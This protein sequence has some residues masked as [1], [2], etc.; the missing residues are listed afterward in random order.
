LFGSDPEQIANGSLPQDDD[1]D[2][3]DDDI[4][5][6][7]NQ[8]MQNQSVAGDD[9]AKTETSPENDDQTDL[10]AIEKWVKPVACH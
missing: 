8:S 1:D 5:S 2:D 6:H 3:D 10:L 4:E 9:E 7:E